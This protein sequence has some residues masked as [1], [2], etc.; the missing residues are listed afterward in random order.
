MAWKLPS[1]DM[2]AYAAPEVL[3][4]LLHTNGC[5]LYALGVIAFEML[6]GRA[7]EGRPR[8][9]VPDRATACARWPIG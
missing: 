2:P 4:N 6:A 9:D 1:I 5:D 7:G 3:T 8:N